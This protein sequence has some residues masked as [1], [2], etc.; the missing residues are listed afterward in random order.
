MGSAGSTRGLKDVAFEAEL[1]LPA[2]Q[3]YAYINITVK[4]ET[5]EEFNKNLGEINADMAAALK[6][7]HDQATAIVMAKPNLPP[8]VSG[9][10]LAEILPPP[11]AVHDTRSAEELIT[12]ELDGK[13]VDVEEKPWER[14]APAV[15]DFF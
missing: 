1:R 13:V 3:Q 5:I 9:M 11:N 6:A 4:G 14:P 15:V 12:Q 7:A 8:S 2:R 10:S